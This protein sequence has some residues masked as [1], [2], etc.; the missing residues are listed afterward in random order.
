M[1]QTIPSSPRS[2]IGLAVWGSV[3]GAADAG[4]EV[5]DGLEV[6]DVVSGVLAFCSSVGAAD[7]VRLDPRGGA[8]MTKIGASAGGGGG[9]G[10]EP[11][12]CLCCSTTVSGSSTTL[13]AD[14]FIPF[15]KPNASTS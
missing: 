9:G 14:S 4:C 10:M 3:V 11:V 2:G 6:P 12:S 15:F 5:S 7:S 8:Y 1:Q 13:V